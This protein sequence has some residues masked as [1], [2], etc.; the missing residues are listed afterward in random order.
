MSFSDASIHVYDPLFPQNIN[1]TLKSASV[2][3]YKNTN[4][5]TNTRKTLILLMESREISRYFFITLW[6]AIFI[7][8]IIQFITSRHYSQK[9]QNDDFFTVPSDFTFSIVNA[10]CGILISIFGL[11]IRIENSVFMNYVSKKPNLVILCGLMASVM[12]L[13]NL[14][15]FL[16]MII[17]GMEKF[18]SEFLTNVKNTMEIVDEYQIKYNCCSWDNVHE[19]QQINLMQEIPESCLGNPNQGCQYV[20]R[21]FI[22]NLGMISV[23]GSVLYFTQILVSAWYY[24]HLK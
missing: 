7:V 12:G 10:I 23:S 21:D 15:N 1:Q 11:S 3:T 20:N 22:L 14:L 6:L 13:L 4:T 18:K 16:M 8:S 5:H 19:F 2:C 17:S 9:L 24:H